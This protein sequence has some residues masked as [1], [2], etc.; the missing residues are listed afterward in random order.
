[1]DPKQIVAHGFDQIAEKYVQWS[2]HTRV[3]ERQ[4]YTSLVIET[5]P[6]GASVLDLGCGIGVPT[7]RELAKHFAVTGVD[8]SPHEI[9]LARHNVPEA[10]FIHADIGALKLASASFDAVVAFYSLFCIPRD[11]HA[12]ILQNIASWL[13]PGGYLFAAMGSQALEAHIE[14]EWL[15]VPMYWSCFESATNQRLVADAGLQVLQ[16]TEETDMEDGVP[17]TFLW[18]VAQKPA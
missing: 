10:T 4:K 18:I 8:I 3:E 16:A 7:T 11:E 13:R 9:E 17:I 15:G 5:L 14:P 12:Q 1:M 6:Q 2:Q